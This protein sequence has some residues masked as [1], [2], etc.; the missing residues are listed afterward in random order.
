MAK[1]YATPYVGTNRDGTAP[2][3]MVDGRMVDAKD[4]RTVAPKDTTN[5]L[6][7][8]DQI[9]IG[10]LPIEA[11]QIRFSAFTDTSFGS[12][13]ISIGTALNPT[14][15]VNAATFTVTGVWTSL[16]LQIAP[17]LGGPLAAEDEVLVTLGVGGIAAAVRA[18]FAFQY[19]I[20]A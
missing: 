20:R 8:G 5:T 4:R 7:A 9:Y 15:Y 2:G 17:A 18:A 11:C 16:P 10:R 6:A 13:T 3:G 14:K 12:T 19:T 1:Y